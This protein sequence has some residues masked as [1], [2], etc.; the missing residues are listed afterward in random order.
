MMGQSWGE[1]GAELRGRWR[2]RLSSGSP[3]GAVR[4]FFFLGG[5]K[6]ILARGNSRDVGSSSS[7]LS[8]DSFLQMDFS[9]SGFASQPSPLEMSRH[10]SS[11]DESPG[12][13]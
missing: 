2:K 7:S 13:G 5:V 9:C 3:Q 1:A 4:R 10:Y 8:W 11:R 12:H 6:L